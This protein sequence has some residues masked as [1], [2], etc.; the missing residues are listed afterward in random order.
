MWTL[1]ALV[2]PSCQYAPMA[3]LIASSLKMSREDISMS[4]LCAFVIASTDETVMPTGRSL[5]AASASKPS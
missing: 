5:L 2:S 1:S 3:F 4:L